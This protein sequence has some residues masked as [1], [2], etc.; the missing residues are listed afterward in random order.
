MNEHERAGMGRSGQPEAGRD[1]P[2]YGVAS[3]SVN[4]VWVLPRMGD[5]SVIVT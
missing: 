2:V 5:Y 3:T 4:A 1:Q